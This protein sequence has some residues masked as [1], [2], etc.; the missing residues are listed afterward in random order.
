M[1]D[2]KVSRY[3]SVT[4][5]VLT[6]LVITGCGLPD[7]P[8]MSG[9]AVPSEYANKHMP[10]GWWT[11]EAIIAEGRQLYLGLKKGYVNC[12]KCHGKTGKP[13]KGGARD[14]RNTDNMKKYSDSHLFWRISEGVPYS[15]MRAYKGKLSEDEIWKIIAFTRTFGLKG[16]QYDPIKKDWVSTGTG[17]PS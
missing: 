10:E 8:Q 1:D 5:L 17:Q 3:A 12:A 4:A 16:L 2:L 7:P 9:N 11:D 15:T 14:F 13:V 6:I